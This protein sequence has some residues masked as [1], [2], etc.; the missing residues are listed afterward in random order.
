MDT[1]H[2]WVKLTNIIVKWS[3]PIESSIWPTK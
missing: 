3:Q 2:F 1:K